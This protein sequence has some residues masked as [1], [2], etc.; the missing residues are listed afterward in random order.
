MIGHHLD[1]AVLV[2][3]AGVRVTAPVASWCDLAGLLTVDELVAAGDFLITGTE[4]YD[5]VTPLASYEQLSRAVSSRTGRRGIRKLR[6]ALPLIRYG[7]LSPKETELRLLIVR[8]GL[9]E[10]V[11]NYVLRDGRGVFV[12]MI[13]LA[14]AEW[15]VGIEYQSDLHRERAQFRRDIGRRER[16]E[17]EGWSVIYV[18]ADD[19]RGSPRQTIDRIRRRLAGRR[20]VE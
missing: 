4:P 9:P 6:Q 11:P 7:S 13:D 8:A 3:I 17:D 16:I 18:S 10:P 20:V 15:K 2:E 14:F 5:G 12:A 1:D 19:L